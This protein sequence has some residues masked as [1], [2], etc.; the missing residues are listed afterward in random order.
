MII[1]SGSNTYFQLGEKSNNVNSNG[2]PIISPPIKSHIDESSIISFS[3]YFD[4]TV[5]ITRDYSA[6]GIGDNSHC[7]I[8][9][10]L[11]K[12]II[13]HITK[14]EI[15][16][17]QNHTYKPT[18]VV[19]GESY[20]LYIA[21]NNSKNQLIYSCSQLNGPHPLFLNTGKEKPVTIFG[22][23]S[24]C[25]SITSDGTILIIPMNAFKFPNRQIEAVSLPSG[26]KAVKIAFMRSFCFILS[27]AG[28]VYRSPLNNG[29]NQISFQ[30]V[31][32]L[33]GVKI[34]SISGSYDHCFCVSA[35]GRVYGCGSNT[36]GQ[37]GVNCGRQ[38][39]SGFIQIM[40]FGKKKIREAFAG[41][42]HSLFIT[43]EGS[44]LAC[45][46]NEGGELLMYGEPSDQCVYIP[47]LTTVVRGAKFCIAGNVSSV[48]FRTD[49]DEIVTKSPQMVQQPKKVKLVKKKAVMRSVNPI[50]KLRKVEEENEALKLEILRLKK[51]R[52]NYIHLNVD[53]K[54]SSPK[55]EK[56]KEKDEKD[57]KDE[58]PEEKK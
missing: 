34:T 28:S 14:F 43:S 23:C 53:K 2:T 40:S 51:E 9:P 30:I 25:A 11:P 8:I 7:E 37:L 36:Y 27:S 41:C 47:K 46:S 49:E 32:E 3:T 24:N 18:T 20:T 16:D 6:H 19:C 33:R 54:K 31:S 48:V 17:S 29:S 58:S 39:V 56:E 50:E 5:F 35:A 13:K 42:S 21:T 15:K 22:G 26:Q 45:G 38:H 10:S 52:S 12:R 4:H 57:S 44:V 55:K 1:V